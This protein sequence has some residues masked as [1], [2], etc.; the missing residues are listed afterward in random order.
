MN[1]LNSNVTINVKDLDKSVSFYLSIGFDL[2]QRWGDHYALLTAPGIEIGLHPTSKTNQEPV[3]KGVS[4]GFTT[5]DFSSVAKELEQLGIIFAE[6]TEE[7]G[8]FIHFHD[9]DGTPLYFIRPKW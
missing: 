6:R 8:D 5:E 1:I 7:G 2:K 9:P 4:T 3:Q